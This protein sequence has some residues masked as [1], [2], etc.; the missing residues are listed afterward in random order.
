MPTKRTW[1]FLFIAIILYFLANQTQIGWIYVISAG[2]I[3]L[4]LAAFLYDRRLL[5]AI[6]LERTVRPVSASR[7]AAAEL[8]LPTFFE[9]DP[10][11]VILRLQT[12]SLR[13]AFMLSGAEQCPFAPPA[14]QV[15]ALFAPA[16]FKGRPLALS[17]QTLA[18]RRG[19]YPFSAI[20]LRSTGPFGFFAAKR[21]VPAPGD[22]LIYPRYYPLKRLALLEK[23]HFGPRET[24][25]VGLGSQVIGTRDYRPGDS[26]R[27]VHWRSTA[28]RG[29][30]VVKEFAAEDQLSLT[31]VLD[32][33]RGS[34]LGH[35]KFATFETAL[36]LAATFAH[37]ADYKKIPLYLAGAS[38]AWSPP[39]TPLS[40]WAT[41][42]Y[43]A[44]VQQDGP[45][46]L[47][48]LLERLPALPFVVVLASA[49]T[50][51]LGSSLAALAQRSGQVLALAL[52]PAETAPLEVSWPER[53]N[54][55]QRPIVATEWLEAVKQL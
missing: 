5:A 16:L 51:E 30:V 55:R 19:V 52:S 27:Q 3:G 9:D 39:Q 4:L 37:Y 41:L 8:T 28:R 1:I 36:R 46:P 44:K 38:P 43:L 54:L 10:V 21:T 6:D 17:Y 20:P 31:V 42:T 12:R 50:A 7:S 11:E 29:S 32:L 53:P 33:Q 47:G 15:Q 13:P 23:R 48:Q 45:Q 35:G 24:A 34:S 2:I 14:E 25:Q 49:P 18:D 40:W 26:L 22:I